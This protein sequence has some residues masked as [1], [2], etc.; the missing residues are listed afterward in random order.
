L[1]L[2]LPAHGR[3]LG[4][5]RRGHVT[6]S[7][8]S[9]GWIAEPELAGSAALGALARLHRL[10]DL[11]GEA[12][13]R[14]ARLESSGA[15]RRLA[16][17]LGF[18]SGG[19][20]TL[21]EARGPGAPRATEWALECERGPLATP[22]SEPAGAL[23]AR[24]LDCFLDRILHAAPPYVSDARVLHVLDLVGAIERRL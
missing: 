15:R 23:F 16:V 1:Q 6:F 9:T 18:A 19:T 20:A 13:V 12:E 11:F 10:V 3:E 14:A 17:E 21:I 8:D 2:A 4:P 7:G 22:P 5:L 24:D